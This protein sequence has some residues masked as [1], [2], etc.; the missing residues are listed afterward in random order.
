MGS[1]LH[2]ASSHMPSET[3]YRSHRPILCCCCLT[4][5]L[6][7]ATTTASLYPLPQVPTSLGACPGG[8]HEGGAGDR[9]KHQKGRSPD[10]LWW[11][12]LLEIN[13]PKNPHP[14]PGRPGVEIKGEKPPRSV[15]LAKSS[16]LSRYVALCS[17]H[18]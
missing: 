9:R 11:F 17:L 4:P 2:A 14:S 6:H 8:L 18:R 7:H 15:S 1:Y 12:F 13:T 16:H 3:Q 10:S 5:A